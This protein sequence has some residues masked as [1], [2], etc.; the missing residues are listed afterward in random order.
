M[1]GSTT[2]TVRLSSKAKKDL[3]RLA[4]AT[5][6]TKSH[7]AANAIVDYVVRESA[8]A[9]EIRQARDEVRTGKAKLIPHD[10]AMARL[11]AR[12]KKVARNKR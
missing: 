1:D 8:I 3:E 6:R 11:R 10:A 12:V 5:D 4:K 2:L 7:L 9:A